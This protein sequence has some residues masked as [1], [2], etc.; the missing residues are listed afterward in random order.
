MGRL[1]LRAKMVV[2]LLTAAACGTKEELWEASCGGSVTPDVRLTAEQRLGKRLFYDKNLSTPPG[3][4]CADCHSPEAGFGDAN[5]NLPVSQ[6]VHKDRFGKRNDLTAAYASFSPAF[7]YDANEN[8]YVGG[9]FWDGR[10]AT[11]E[12]QAKGPF[13]NVLE[14]ANPN[15]EVVI[16]KIRRSDYA[17]LFREVFGPDALRNTARAYNLAAQAIAAYERSSELNQFSS[18]YDF[19]LKKKVQLSEQQMKGLVL[20]EDKNKGNCAACHPSRPGPDGSP[21]LFTDYTYD[22]LGIPKN[23]ENPFY[24]LPKQFNPDGVAFVDQGLGAVVNKTE[25]NGKFKVPSLRNIAR[26]SPYSHNGFFKT[27]RQIVVFYN[28]R[29]LGLWPPPEVAANVNRDELGNLGLTQQEV[30]DIVAFLCTLTDGYD[31]NKNQ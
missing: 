4:A 7:H 22:N 16:E 13:L 17:D 8:A 31:P 21:P 30:D 5:P 19:Y 20:F 18:K 15:E 11:L 23:P 1:S 26:T 12:E 27:L 29:D 9:Y 2:L 25:H 24:Y 6:G 3:Q 28:T 10:A 14:M